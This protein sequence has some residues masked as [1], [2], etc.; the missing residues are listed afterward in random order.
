M[1]PEVPAEGGIV[2]IL[3][4]R[5]LVRLAFSRAQEE[6][7]RID[8]ALARVSALEVR[9]A[10]LEARKARRPRKRPASAVERER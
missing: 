2:G 1:T 4:G 6:W 5:P 3:Q 10:A 9:V 8:D 7:G